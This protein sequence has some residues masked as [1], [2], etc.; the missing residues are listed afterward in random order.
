MRIAGPIDRDFGKRLQFSFR[1]SG[2]HR[3]LPVLQENGDVVVV[4]VRYGQVRSVVPVEIPHR[5]RPWAVAPTKVDGGL[6][7]PATIP[8]EHGYVIVIYI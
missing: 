8:Q 2:K 7:G 6:E 4:P 3:G 1:Q 5:Q